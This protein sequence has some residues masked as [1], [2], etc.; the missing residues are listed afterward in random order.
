MSTP[1]LLLRISIL[2]EYKDYAIQAEIADLEEML[3]VMPGTWWN[4]YSQKYG[5]KIRPFPYSA[6]NGFFFDIQSR[7]ALYRFESKGIARR[8]E[9]F[10]EEDYTKIVPPVYRSTWF[11]LDDA[12]RCYSVLIT[13]IEKLLKPVPVEDFGLYNS[14]GKVSTKDKFHHPRL[15]K[16]TWDTM[17]SKYFNYD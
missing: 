13:S 16:P 12:T 11:D 17:K 5:T 14:W 8:D 7:K 4:A 2:D 15:I 1:E 6:R 10:H 3:E 9:L